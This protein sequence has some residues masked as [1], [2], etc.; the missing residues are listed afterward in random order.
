MDSGT[1]VATIGGTDHRPE[2][3]GTI[4]IEWKDNNEIAHQ[5]MLEKALYF[6]NSLVNTISITLLAEWLNDDEE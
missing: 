3:I 1:G 2:R 6:P 4:Q 5:C